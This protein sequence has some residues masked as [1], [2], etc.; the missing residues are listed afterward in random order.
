LGSV[1]EFCDQ[2]VL[3]NRTVLAYGPTA[4]VFTEQNL[5]VAFGGLLREFQFEQSTIQDHD[6][7]KVR[8]FSDDERPLVFGKDGHLEYRD[9]TDH[10]DLLKRRSEQDDE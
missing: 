2:V 9:R 8:V 4:E 10:E 5:T 3:M 7:R 6:G 1:P